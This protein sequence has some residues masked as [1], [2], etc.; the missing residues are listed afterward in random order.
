ME[1]YIL[2]NTG[3]EMLWK[4]AEKALKI[5][6]VKT[7]HAVTGQYDVVIHVVFENMKALGELIREIHTLQ[8]VM[9]THTAVVIP[10]RIY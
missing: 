1:A 6:G 2:V 7:A 4:V 5:E 3:P 10:P 9:K 8:G